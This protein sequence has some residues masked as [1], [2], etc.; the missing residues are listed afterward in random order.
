METYIR[1]KLH[2]YYLICNAVM[3][4]YLKGLQKIFDELSK[5][6][7]LWI[8]FFSLNSLIFLNQDIASNINIAIKK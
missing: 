2:N 1:A 6:K 5:Y 8:N 3:S 7:S 4:V